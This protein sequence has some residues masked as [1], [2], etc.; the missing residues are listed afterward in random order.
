MVS[1]GTF[2][3]YGSHT[4]LEESAADHSGSTPYMISITINHEATVPQT[5]TTSATVSDPPVVATG[6]FAFVVTEGMPS[7]VQTV[8]TFTDPGGPES[9]GDYKALIDW[10]DGTAPSQGMISSSDGVF[11]VKGSHTFAVGLGLP[12]DFGNTLCDAAAPSF[13]KAITV[14]ISHEAA[15]VSMA[16]STSTISLAPGTAHLT[17]DGNLI[18][19][20]T[21]ASDQI[22][23]DPVGNTGAVRVS[24]NSGVL[25]SFTLG[26]GGRIIVAAMGGD[27]D[28]QVAGGV[29][30]PAVLSGGPGNDR[31]KAGNGPSILVGC[32]GNDD[33]TGGNSDDL[34]IG[35]DGA[36]SLNGTAGDDIL[37][38]SNIIDPVTHAEDVTFSHL[39]GAL[40]GSPILFDDDGSVDVLNGASGSNML[41]FNPEDVVHG[42]QK[43]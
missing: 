42:K 38:A 18:V 32:D 16:T 24:L 15:P 35:G 10:G 26:A 39:I 14:S 25:G 12:D 41:Y 30:L 19:V 31:I 21:P 27:D 7:A 2:Q 11:T 5:V 3:V 23:V 33:L 20:G 22:H 34:L 36:D 37:V 9:L 6:G 40:D 29:R 8:A 17:S 1:G 28:I 43:K 13:H 4:Y